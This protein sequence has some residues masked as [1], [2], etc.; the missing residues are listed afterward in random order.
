MKKKFHFTYFENIVT[1][2]L[3]IIFCITSTFVQAQ[4]IEINNLLLPFYTQ[5]MRSNWD[6]ITKDQFGV[7]GSGFIGTNEFIGRCAAK[8]D[9]PSWW[10]GPSGPWVPITGYKQTLCGYLTMH[11]NFEENDDDHDIDFYIVPNEA[12]RFL[13][14]ESRR[15]S[16]HYYC[17]N[18]ICCEIAFMEP[19]NTIITDGAT[20]FQSGMRTKM[21]YKNIGV[22]GAFVY[23]DNHENSPEIHPIEQMW[24][25]EE[26]SASK[27]E[28]YLYSMH[29]NQDRFGKKE[30]YSNSNECPQLP[31]LK[32]PQ[33][34]TFYIPFEVSLKST[35]VLDF[36][37]DLLS[38]NNINY[39]NT[40]SETIRLL[41][42][43]KEIVRVKKVKTVSLPNVKIFPK[44]YF[45]ELGMKDRETIRGYIAI[46]TSICQPGVTSGGHE[47]LKLTR[48]R[49]PGIQKDPKIPVLKKL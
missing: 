12:F 15:P 30:Y 29:D 24:H 33:V 26:I 32:N 19:G 34:N 39:D 49:M 43:G 37:I 23:D 25:K 13:L 14:M 22:Y 31:W 44:V 11:K 42:N 41:K 8:E 21:E 47:F 6:T 38:G 4:D 28:F 27:T 9:D 36:N 17:H 2:I 10:E 48:T 1:N 40:T 20:Y 5:K 7:A 3:I 18:A 35:N 46:E 45:Y 16:G